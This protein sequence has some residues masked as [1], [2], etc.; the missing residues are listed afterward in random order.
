MGVCACWELSSVHEFVFEGAEKRFSH[1]IVLTDTGAA[2]RRSQAQRAELA[3]K[4]PRRVLTAAI[5]MKYAAFDEVD[6]PGRRIECIRYERGLH[7]VG[8]RPADHSFGVAVDDGREIQ[9]PGPGVNVGDI[10]DQFGTAS[11]R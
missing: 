3:T 5:G 2:G 1:R 7:V 10:A 11:Q 4:V 6:V 9:E 8:H